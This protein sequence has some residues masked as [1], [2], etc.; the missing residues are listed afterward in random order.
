MSV[1]QKLQN[2]N[3]PHDSQA[4]KSKCQLAGLDILF[5]EGLAG[6]DQVNT[7]AGTSWSGE[8]WPVKQPRHCATLLTIAGHGTVQV[9]VSQTWT[10]FLLLLLQLGLGGHLHLLRWGCGAGTRGRAVTVIGLSFARLSFLDCFLGWFSFSSWSWSSSIGNQSIKFFRFIVR[11]R[12][13]RIPFSTKINFN[14]NNPKGIK[15]P[16]RY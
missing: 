10:R 6:C 8:C 5:S 11:L 15:S 16:L 1:L 14:I 2:F 13:I 4:K 9:T 12:W 7:N 3:L